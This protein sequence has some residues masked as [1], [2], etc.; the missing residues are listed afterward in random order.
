MVYACKHGR[1]AGDDAAMTD[2]QETSYPTLA[3]KIDRLIKAKRA[4]D[5]RNLSYKDLATAISGHGGSS[6]SAAYLWQLHTGA[7]DNP[8]KK[9][10]ETLAGFF[11]VPVT[12]FF[13]TEEAT[14]LYEELPIALDADVRKMALRAADLSPESREVIG[15]MIE[16][17]R[18]IDAMYSGRRVPRP[19]QSDGDEH[20]M[21]EADQG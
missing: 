19:P 12:Y 7:K 4:R 21:K 14:R 8:Q 20:V 10:L 5:R 1:W 3:E 11:G 18:R 13:D 15:Q 9:V 17:A 2:G 16:Q 6:I